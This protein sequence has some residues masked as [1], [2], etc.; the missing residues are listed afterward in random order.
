MS[1]F[2]RL[3]LT[4]AAA[5]L[6]VSMVPAGA[7]SA[8][9]V[10]PDAL[11][12]QHVTKLSTGMPSTLP[13]VGA[14][15]LWDAGVSWKHIETSNDVYD[16]AALDNA[17]ANAEKLGAREILYTLGNTPSWAASDPNSKDALYGPGSNSHPAQNSY[18]TDFLKAVA[19]RYKG[20]ITAYQ[21]WNEANLKDFYLGTP[22]QMAKL[23][24]AGRSALKSVDSSAKW[25]AASTTVR[26]TGPVGKWGK[27]YGKAMKKAKW[28]VD[29]VSAHF[30]PPATSGPSTRVSYIKKIK[31]Y[32]KKWG[33]KKKPLWDTEMNYGDLRSY[34]KV[35]KE[36]TGATAATYVARTYIDS[37]RYGVS[38][39]FW[40]AWD[41]NVL[42]TAMTKDG[43]IQSGGIA[44]QQI[45]NWMSGKAWLGC[46]VK[47]SITTC[48]VRGPS[49]KQYIRYA[50]KKKKFKATSAG[51]LYFL[52]GTSA[53][54]AKGQKVRL[55]TQPVL[56]G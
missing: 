2:S 54:V 20:R 34:M 35:K 10:V 50:A 40:Y 32:Y 52:D 8:A 9:P 13:S 30:Y 51:T 29:V 3:A 37:M 43:A 6:V 14:I 48:T 5:G 21:A 7:A 42:G 38:R 41:N 36:Y 15:R 47:A 24:K 31:S 16:W 19:T 1:M 44:F 4:A 55:R 23:T 12:G 26:S 22:T 25:V 49:G 11:F 39:V 45:R 27:A 33:A 46:K 18:Y 53:P 28:P 17:V 56:F